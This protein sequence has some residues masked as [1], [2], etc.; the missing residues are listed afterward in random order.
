MH[1]TPTVN[2]LLSSLLSAHAELSGALQVAGVVVRPDGKI[3]ED[4]GQ[5]AD[6]RTVFRIAS[7]T[8]S[9]TAALVLMLR[10]EGVLDLDRPIADY[11]PE[12]ATVVGPGPAPK[13]ITLRDL[14]SMSSGLV[15]DDPWADRHLDA[16]DADLDAWVADGLRFAHPTGTAFEYSNLGF[17]LVG[18]VVF[19]VTGER[20]QELVTKRILAPLGMAHTV[21]EE[22]SL[23]VGSEIAPGWMPADGNLS[24]V[25]P[26]GDGVIAPM[27]G[28][29]SNCEDL[30]KWV[31]LLSGAFR[32]AAPDG[33]IRKTSLREM[34]QVQRGYTS[35]VVPGLDGM[36][37]RVQGGYGFGLNVHLDDRHGCV[38]HSGGLPGYGST[39]RWAPGGGGVVLLAN[40]TYAP[41]TVAGARLFD[42]LRHNGYLGPE[43]KPVDRDVEDA[44]RA[45]AALF[46]DWSE[47][48]ADDLF[49]DNVLPD[50]AAPSRIA[51]AQGKLA[52]HKAEFVCVAMD[53]DP[54]LTLRA[55]DTLHRVRF[56]LAPIAPTRVQHYRWL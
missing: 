21:W 13:P 10:D 9:F 54:V 33:P 52:G 44:G 36:D 32:A 29:W 16:S 22:D 15:T 5:S 6:S 46:N 42:A 26:L 24:K 2:A 38:W 47:P 17:A 28:L 35:R 8:K 53:P 25:K 12:L 41:M 14:L 43:S 31:G 37:F 30:A 3:V 50:Q 18:R 45:L 7:M 49:A 40:L 51:E 11:A 55:G 4:W 19:R 39:M 34:Q 56:M 27:G 20:L 1:P 23:P 48:N